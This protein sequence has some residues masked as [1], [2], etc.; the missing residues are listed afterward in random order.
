MKR[1]ST[2]F[3]RIVVVLVGAPVL[4]LC[5]AALPWL[6]GHPANPE[7][8]RMLYPLVAGL[9]LSAAPFFFALHQTFKLLRYIDRSQAFS[10]LSIQALKNIKYCAVAVSALYTFMLPFIYLLADRD[11]APG[12]AL[13]GIICTFAALVIA[14]FAAVLQRLLQE[15]IDIKSEND[16]TV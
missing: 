1:G 5:L 15:A 9:Y 8:A 10:Q 16:L 13:M 3:L 4:G 14:V 7:Y 6:A 2:L 12:L 11:D